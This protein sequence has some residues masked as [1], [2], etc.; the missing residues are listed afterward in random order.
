MEIKLPMPRWR[1]RIA[2]IPC[3]VD[4]IH[5]PQN[6]GGL[7]QDKEWCEVVSDGNRRRIRFH[8]YGKIF[9]IPGLY[10]R[11]FYERLKCC[12]P[13]RVVRLLADVASEQRGGLKSLR[14]LDLGAGNG[15]VGDELYARGVRQIVG[16][17]IIPEARDATLRDRPGIYL[18]YLVTDMTDLPASDEDKLRRARCNCL[19]TVAA[20]GFADIPPMAFIK[21]LTLIETPGLVAFNIK[22][23]FLR[24]EDG[25]GFS[26]LIRRL[27]RDEVI[28]I[29]A[30]RRY[31]H[32]LSMTGAPLYYVAMVV[33]KLKEPVGELTELFN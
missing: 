9:D 25:T 5:L 15:M 1:E 10:E 32:R 13:S 19:L 11:L 24:E 28:Q 3:N 8:D 12:S 30:Y 6:T 4:A 27:S 22:E 14:A 33:R 16:I 20:L 31:R 2:E 21:G 29:Q 7:S 26:R 23:D 17:D 18:D